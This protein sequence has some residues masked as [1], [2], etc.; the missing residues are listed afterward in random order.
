MELDELIKKIDKIEQKLDE[1]AVQSNKLA[2]NYA[3]VSQDVSRILE[4]NQLIRS[5][6]VKTAINEEKICALED[7]QNVLSKKIEDT[8]SD[9]NLRV[10]R[11]AGAGWTLLVLAITQILAFIVMILH[12][13]LIK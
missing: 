4:I 2:T 10:H 9:F 5:V 13:K 1:I 8:Q 12:D 11:L 6:E 7:Q 3:L